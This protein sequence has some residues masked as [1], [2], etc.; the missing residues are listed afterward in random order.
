MGSKTIGAPAYVGAEIGA[1]GMM[2]DEDGRDYA[3]RSGLTVAD[4]IA[5]LSEEP[6]GGD[7]RYAVWAVYWRCADGEA[8]HV[9]DFEFSLAGE[10]RARA[11]YAAMQAGAQVATA[12]AADVLRIRAPHS[13]ART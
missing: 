4:A 13:G 9:A 7:G 6:E 10:I 8:E 3:E 11:L 12:A 1:C 5:W 2:P